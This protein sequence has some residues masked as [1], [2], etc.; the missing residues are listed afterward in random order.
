MSQIWSN[1]EEKDEDEDEDVETLSVI[2]H[3]SPLS[4]VHVFPSPLFSSFQIISTQLFAPICQ[5]VYPWHKQHQRTENGV[6]IVQQVFVNFKGKLILVSAA[7]VLWS[8][9]RVDLQRNTLPR[10]LSSL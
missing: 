2:Y 3:F 8:I 5:T 10:R 6:L 7:H 1:E 4:S 9:D